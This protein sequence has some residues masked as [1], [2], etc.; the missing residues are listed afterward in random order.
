[1][2][3]ENNTPPIVPDPITPMPPIT[4]YDK[5]IESANEASERLEAANKRAEEIIVKANQEA[6]A[7]TLGGQASAGEEVK[8]LTEDEKI[9]AESKKIL[10]GTGYEDM[11]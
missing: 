10:A 5:K 6:V 2:T 4:D 1:M 7:R 9:T 3:D 8:Q 11:L